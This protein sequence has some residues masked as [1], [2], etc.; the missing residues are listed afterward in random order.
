MRIIKEEKFKKIINREFNF[1]F[2]ITEEGLYLVE[3]SAR[4]RSEKQIG[5]NES[6]DDDLRVEIDG[7]KFGQPSDP[8]RYLDSPAAFS[9][10]QIYNL[11]KTVVFVCQFSEGNH[12]INFIPDREPTL[13]EVKIYRPEIENGKLV[14]ALNWQAEDGDRRDWCTVALIDLPLKETIIELTCQKRKFDRDDVKII[15]DGEIKKNLKSG[16]RKFWYWLGAFSGSEKQ[17]N[18][19]KLDKERRPV[20]YIEFWADRMPTLNQAVLDFGENLLKRIPTVYDPEWVGDFRSDPEDILLSR[21]ILGEA[22]GQ[23]Q[24]VKTWI[25]GSIL[26]RMRAKAWP[27]TIQDVILQQGQYDPFKPA[28]ANFHK[29]TDPLEDA[30]SNRRNSWFISYKIASGILSGEIKNPTEATHFH[31]KGVTKEWFME[32]VVP[33]GKFLKKIE[34]TYFYWSRN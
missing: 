6:D 1:E 5:K 28:D 29:I 23:S 30:D 10:G 32:N 33:N 20:H 16:F 15:I 13:E 12:F 34:D 18:T 11:K 3:I 27:D 25:A 17:I 4:A 19:F 8:N 9:G 22:E 31:G 14:A 24:E 7:R 26:N 21:L 2:N